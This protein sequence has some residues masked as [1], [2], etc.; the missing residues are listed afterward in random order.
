MD[1]RFKGVFPNRLRYLSDF[2]M[3]RMQISRNPNPGMSFNLRHLKYFVAT[4]E[5]G[6]VSRA[7][8]ELSVSQS[9]VT[10]AIKELEAA[11]DTA[12]FQRSAQGMTLTQAGRRFLASAYEILSKVEEALQ[13]HEGPEVSGQLNVAASYT[14]IGYFLPVHFERLARA[15]PELRLS[16]HEMSREMIEEGL[17]AGRFDI[18]V[19]LTSNITNPEIAAQTLIRSPRRLWT[20]PGTGCWSARR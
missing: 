1:S 17:I 14:V 3:M 8:I 13:I 11:L 4:A 20:P 9:A 19:A 7:A 18:G 15:Q 16:L 5:L 2:P 12:L 6:Q 10:A